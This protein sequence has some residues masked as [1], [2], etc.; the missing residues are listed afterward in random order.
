MKESL[1]FT[2]ATKIIKYIG[3]NIPKQIEE[4]YTDNYKTLMKE[5]KYDINRWRDIP[6][7]W[8]G[9]ISIMLNN[10]G[11]SGHPC[12]FMIPGEMSSVFQH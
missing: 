8:V 11:E 3:I 10:S 4:L 1:P 12:L 2:I 9:K 7:C 5:I 6:C